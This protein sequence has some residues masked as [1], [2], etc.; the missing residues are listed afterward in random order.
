M[1]KRLYHLRGRGLGSRC[2]LRLWQRS[3]DRRLCRFLERGRWLNLPG[4]LRCGP[5]LWLRFFDNL[6]WFWLGLRLLRN[7]FW[8]WLW[9]RFLGDWFRLR[10]FGYR[11]GRSRLLDRLRL[12][13]WGWGLFRLGAGRS[14]RG[15]LATHWRPLAQLQKQVAGRLGRWWSRRPDQQDED[16]R[17]YCAAGQG[18]QK[19]PPLAPSLVF[20]RYAAR[21]QQLPPPRAKPR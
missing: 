17:Q 1:G 9:L 2:R 7:R 12:R 6:S 4:R 16:K 18:K 15:F 20:S 19:R 14:R 5:W 21:F 13:W 8:L 11:L 10:L 3:P